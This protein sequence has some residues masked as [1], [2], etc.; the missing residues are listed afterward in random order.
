MPVDTPSG[1][2]YRTTIT[3][4]AG[5]RGREYIR[6]RP[7]GAWRNF[8]EMSEDDVDVI[9]SFVRRHGDPSG[10]LE[11]SGMSDLSGWSAFRKALAPAA[12]LWTAKNADGIQSSTLASAPVARR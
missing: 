8:C 7:I 11:V 2:T 3:Y 5:G 4:L 10:H 1:R 6:T 9:L 12:G